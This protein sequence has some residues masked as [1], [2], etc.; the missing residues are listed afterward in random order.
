MERYLPTRRS[1]VCDGSVLILLTE[2][3]SIETQLST[4]DWFI[5]AVK[6]GIGGE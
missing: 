3:G 5:Y 2:Y 6:Y 1:T 4:S